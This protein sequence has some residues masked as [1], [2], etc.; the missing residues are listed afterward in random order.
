MQAATTSVTKL[1]YA[2]SLVASQALNNCMVA[3]SVQVDHV[4]YKMSFG[5]TGVVAGVI[6]TVSKPMV[7]IKIGT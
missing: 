1:E 6:D 2:S 3:L 7:M 4:W 5:G